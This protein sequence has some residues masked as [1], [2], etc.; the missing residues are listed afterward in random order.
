VERYL[1]AAGLEP[2]NVLSIGDG[3]NDFE[4]LLNSGFSVAMANAKNAVLQVA[5]NITEDNDDDGVALALEQ[6]VL[7]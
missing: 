3:M 7:K 1:Q 6:F 4:M 2:D 5:D